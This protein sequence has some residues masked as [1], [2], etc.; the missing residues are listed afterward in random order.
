ME[1]EKHKIAA[2]FVCV[3]VSSASTLCGSYLLRPIINGLIDFDQ[4][5]SAKY[6]ACK[7]R[8]LRPLA[9]VYVLGVG[10]ACLQGRI[11]ISVSQ[12]L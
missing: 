4:N 7:V 3:L 1:Q 9:A 12:G 8:D 11:M 2:A 10:A 5:T 6:F